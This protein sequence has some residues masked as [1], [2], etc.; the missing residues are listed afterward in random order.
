MARHSS[1]FI[2]TEVTS[3]LHHPAAADS[4]QGSPD[5]QDGRVS[6]WG[7]SGARGRGRGRGAAPTQDPIYKVRQS[8]QCGR[9]LGLCSA[10]TTGSDTKRGHKTTSVAKLQRRAASQGLSAGID[11]FARRASEAP[12]HLFK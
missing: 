4:K 6:G 2:F 9:K 10:E 7:G 12:G 5:R 3:V 11:L 1:G 8:K